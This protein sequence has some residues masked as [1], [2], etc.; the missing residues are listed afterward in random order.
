[1]STGLLGERGGKNFRCRAQVGV[2][3]SDGVS[4]PW[5]A[6]VGQG[7]LVR[8]MARSRRRVGV[9]GS[10]HSMKGMT[11]PPGCSPCRSTHWACEEA[12]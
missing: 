5:L 3:G 12:I 11:P 6:A 1:M 4:G 7:G 9:L 2:G 8:A 10:G